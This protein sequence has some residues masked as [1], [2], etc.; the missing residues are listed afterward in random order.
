MR[1]FYALIRPRMT[2]GMITTGFLLVTFVLYMLVIVPSGGWY[3]IEGVCGVYFWG[4]HEHDGVWHIALIETAFRTWPFRLPV[5]AGETLRNYNYFFDLV[6]YLLSRTGIPSVTWYFKIQPIVWFVAFVFLLRQVGKLAFAWIQDDREIKA[7]ERMKR[8][9]VFQLL[10]LGMVLCAT[11]FGF[12][13]TWYHERTWSG[14][15]SLLAMQGPVGMVN[16]QFMWS[17]VSLLGL[18]YS[19]F[20]FFS[21]KKPSKWIGLVAL[22]VWVSLALKA[23]TIVSVVVI[24]LGYF[25]FHIRGRRRPAVVYGLVCGLAAV[26]AYLIFYQGTDGGLVWAPFELVR[27]VYADPHLLGT[28]DRMQ[29]WFFLKNS[30]KFS[31]RLLYYQ[32]SATMIYLGASYGVRIISLF[33][34]IPLIWAA[35]QRRKLPASYLKIMGVTM[36]SVLLAVPAV[37]LIQK[38]IW[39]NTVQFVYYSIF[40]LSFPAGWMLYLLWRWRPRVCAICITLCILL[41][42]PSHVDT[43]RN[44]TSFR[45]GSYISQ[46]ELEALEVLRRL[47]DGVVYQ[48]PFDPVNQSLLKTHRP[49]LSYTLDTAYVS[50]Y[51]GKP[52]YIANQTQL[53]LL[54]VDFA[55][56][57]EDTRASRCVLLNDIDHLYLQKKNTRFAAIM[58]CLKAKPFR[59]VFENAFSA[60]WSRSPLKH[61]K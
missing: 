54:N 39:W 23:Y 14:S 36:G 12:L 20:Q 33:G 19:S 41:Q 8:I 21:A 38:G 30:G 42:V 7:P 52:T 59:L 32:L 3:C 18:I 28:E 2:V 34:L 37:L 17:L 57:R 24:C 60:V 49:P 6:L 43:I 47:P 13:F 29:R 51:T 1:Y 48:L 53:E 31:P 46:V 9:Q 22:C 25:C 5:Y 45:H 15:S 50:A 4:A 10:Q 40:F 16:P 35:L 44:F 27:G 56:R 61:I 58:Q 26:V 55:Q 11:S